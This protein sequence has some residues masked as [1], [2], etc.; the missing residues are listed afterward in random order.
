ISQAAVD[1]HAVKSHFDRDRDQLEVVTLLQAGC[2]H[3]MKAF[4]IENLNVDGLIDTAMNDPDAAGG[5]VREFRGLNFGDLRTAYRQFCKHEEP[6][7]PVMDLHDVIDFYNKA[8][9]DLPVFDKAKLRLPGIN[10][11]LDGNGRAFADMFQDNRRSQWIA[12]IKVPAH[13]KNAF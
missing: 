2:S 10:A 13:V 8:A 5:E 12:L 11:V 1:P 3:M 7:A 6:A 9:A 4:E